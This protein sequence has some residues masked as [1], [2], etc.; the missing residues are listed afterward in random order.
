MRAW[1]EDDFRREKIYREI[2]GPRADEAMAA[3]YEQGRHERERELQDRVRHRQEREE[4][5]RV[6]HEQ[7]RRT[8]AAITLAPAP[9]PKVSGGPVVVAAGPYFGGPFVM[10]DELVARGHKI[11]AAFEREFNTPLE[12]PVDKVNELLSGPKPPQPAKAV[13]TAPSYLGDADFSYYTHVADSPEFVA[14]FRE[15]VAEIRLECPSH[16]SEK[17][18]DFVTDC[19]APVPADFAFLPEGNKWNLSGY[20]QIRVPE[21]SAKLDIFEQ[22]DPEL[23]T[24]YLREKAHKSKD[25]KYLTIVDVKLALALMVIDPARF[26]ITRYPQL[27]R[28]RGPRKPKEQQA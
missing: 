21:D 9:S 4:Q 12:S 25:E 20:I 5:V 23:G 27:K 17:F 7:K 14:L 10:S 26:K 8:L 11:D 28:R 18:Q 3:N 6:R 1:S 15:I 19:H 24:K 13:K 16:K 22:V 2:M